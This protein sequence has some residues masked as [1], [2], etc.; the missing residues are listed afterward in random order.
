MALTKIQRLSIATGISAGFFM[1]ELGGRYL[2]IMF[3]SGI[4]LTS[5]RPQLDSAL[6]HL[7]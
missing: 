3:V 1:A 4:S 6:G 5:L 2:R 7:H